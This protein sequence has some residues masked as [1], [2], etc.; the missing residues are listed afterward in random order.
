MK[1]IP[2]YTAGMFKKKMRRFGAASIKKP[3]MPTPPKP[4][5]KK[6]SKRKVK[7]LREGGDAKSDAKSDAT[8]LAEYY[9][10]K[11]ALEGLSRRRM[12]EDRRLAKKAVEELMRNP[13]YK[14]RGR[15]L[16]N[17]TIPSEDDYVLEEEVVTPES[18]REEIARARGSSQRRFNIGGKINGIAKRGH[19]RGRII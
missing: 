19:T 9:L 17:Y 13:P 7:F 14:G 1:R 18:S 6:P 16:E 5:A 10:S 15:K 12:E 2:K 3:R 8:Q 11:E 4:K